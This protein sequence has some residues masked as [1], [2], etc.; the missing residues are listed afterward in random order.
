MK[1]RTTIDGSVVLIN[2]R[3]SST[4]MAGIQRCSRV[5][6]G[7]FPKSDGSSLKR[8]RRDGAGTGIKELDVEYIRLVFQILSFTD[9]QLMDVGD[10]SRYGRSTQKFLP[11]RIL[12]RDRHTH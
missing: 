3:K 6:N 4:P 11:L 2:V 8:L 7:N 5:I 12:R 10:I 9:K 1:E